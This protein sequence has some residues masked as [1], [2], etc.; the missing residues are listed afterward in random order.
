[1]VHGR[2][3]RPPNT[4]RLY[5]LA[6]IKMR[7]TD[8]ISDGFDHLGHQKC[9]R[10]INSPV[11]HMNLSYYTIKVRVNDELQNS[12]VVFLIKSYTEENS[13][14]RAKIFCQT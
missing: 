11:P 10:P 14:R 1:M 4:M 7:Q 13:W 2:F 5:R 8:L 9:R 3:N 6:Q 12:Q